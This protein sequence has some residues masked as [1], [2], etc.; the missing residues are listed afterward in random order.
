MSFTQMSS[1]PGFCRPRVPV[2]P[3]RLGVTTAVGRGVKVG[4]KVAEAVGREVAVCVGRAVLV[5]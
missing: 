3:G 2:G 4:A 1:K 5:G